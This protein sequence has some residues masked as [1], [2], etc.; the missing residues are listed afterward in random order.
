MDV[1]FVG[2]WSGDDVERLS[3]MLAKSLGVDPG[4]G[5][6]ALV[7]SLDDNPVGLLSPR[8]KHLIG[9]LRQAGSAFLGDGG[10]VLSK[11]VVPDHVCGPDCTEDH[12]WEYAYG[13]GELSK[14]IGSLKRVK[15][16][17]YRLNANNRWEKFGVKGG[18]GD[19]PEL[20]FAPQDGEFGRGIYLEVGEP[21]G[22]L[23][24]RLR[25]AIAPEHLLTDTQFYELEEDLAGNVESALNARGIRAI[26][27]VQGDKVSLVVVRRGGD[28]EIQGAIANSGALPSTP[29]YRYRIVRFDPQEDGIVA[30]VEV[31]PDQE[32]APLGKAAVTESK[33]LFP[34]GSPLAGCPLIAVHRPPLSRSLVR[35]AVARCQQD[36]V[37]LSDIRIRLAAAVPDFLP[38]GTWVFCLPSTPEIVLVAHDPYQAIAQYSSYLVHRL[39]DYV[40]AGALPG[41]E[42]LEV[43]ERAINLTPDWWLEML[44]KRYAGAIK[45]AQ[46]VGNLMAGSHPQNFGLGIDSAWVPYL[47]LLQ[48]RGVAHWGDRRSIM[49]AIAEDYRVAH[50]PA[51]LPNTVTMAWDILCPEL[52]RLCQQTVLSLLSTYPQQEPHG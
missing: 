17:T 34:P 46:R 37:D 13:W 18:G 1:E 8:Q 15:G 30:D 12:A 27:Q 42:A 39:R 2:D 49:M 50:D 25:L 32:P 45:A 47:E 33:V 28:I 51:G 52:A 10:A 48:A 16:V 7:P 43:A 31:S 21:H 26:A 29:T 38:M 36:G 20:Q 24:V 35:A 19:D 3:G 6:E 4:G 14:A 11:S 5:A 44:I 23:R 9:L 40:V 22:W 41:D